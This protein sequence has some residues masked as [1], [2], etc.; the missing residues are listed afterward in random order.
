MLINGP[1]NKFGRYS[2]IYSYNSISLLTRIV[3]LLIRIPQNLLRDKTDV[4]LPLLESTFTASAHQPIT[5]RHVLD[6]IQNMLIVQPPSFWTTPPP[7]IALKIL[8]LLCDPRPKIRKR[9]GEC[10]RFWLIHP[11]SPMLRHPFASVVGNFIVNGL[12][13]TMVDQKAD[14]TAGDKSLSRK[15]L[16]VQFVR[17]VW[18]AVPD[19]VK[20]D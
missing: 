11:P 10:L 16:L 4:I 15:M 9:A 18:S 8:A 17:L 7:S 2:C 3:I 13:D 1:I 20:P 6:L 19:E 14:K 12:D 5:I